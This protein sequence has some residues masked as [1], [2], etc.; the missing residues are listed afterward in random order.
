MGL[1]QERALG[2]LGASVFGA[3]AG[4]WAGKAGGQTFLGALSGGVGAES[5]GNFCE[6]AVAGSVVVGL[7]YAMYSIDDNDDEWMLTKDGR[8]IKRR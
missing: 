6:G 2:S 7:N 8:I 4:D 1:I 3:I 5:G